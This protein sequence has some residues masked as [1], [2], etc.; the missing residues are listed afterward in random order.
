[1]NQKGSIRQVL[2]QKGVWPIVAVT[3]SEV[4]WALQVLLT[5]PYK[6]RGDYI[7]A[8]SPL[9]RILFLDAGFAIR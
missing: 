8:G 5:L 4:D 7:S 1:M 6:C 9:R 2:E 3:V